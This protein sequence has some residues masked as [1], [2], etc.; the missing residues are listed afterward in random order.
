LTGFLVPCFCRRLRGASWIGD[1][2][3][4]TLGAAWL[5]AVVGD[6]H[7]FTIALRREAVA[8]YAV[9]GEPHDDGVGA[10]LGELLV[11]CI[12]AHIVG[13]SLHF[14]LQ[15]LIGDDKIL[16][17]LQYGVRCGLQGRLIEVEK[18]AIKCHVTRLRETGTEIVSG[19]GDGDG[20]SVVV[21]MQ[22][23]PDVAAV[24][25]V[26]SGEARVRP[27]ELFDDLPSRLGERVAVCRHEH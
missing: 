19:V 9:G 3:A 2:D 16:D 23:C 21:V 8:G 1:L 13:V 15:R 11:V 4:A 24:L 20:V 18:H 26:M 5:G 25:R 17:L 22:D 6:G 7:R 27:H 10:I 14:E 12:I